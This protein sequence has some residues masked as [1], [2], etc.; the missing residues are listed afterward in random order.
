MLSK[1]KEGGGQKSLQDDTFSGPP[2]AGDSLCVFLCQC[3]GCCPPRLV[4]CHYQGMRQLLC[5]NGRSWL[6]SGRCDSHWVW[7]LSIDKERNNQKRAPWLHLSSSISRLRCRLCS[8]FPE[9]GIL[10][11]RMGEKTDGPN[12]CWNDFSVMFSCICLLMYPLKA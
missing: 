1:Q 6:H 7:N 5:R 4:W 10:L 12:R 3:P 9:D 2:L 11:Q 8:I